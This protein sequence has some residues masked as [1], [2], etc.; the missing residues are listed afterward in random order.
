[1]RPPYFFTT[2]HNWRLWCVSSASAAKKYTCIILCSVCFVQTTGWVVW[3]ASSFYKYLQFRT[4]TSPS[5]HG[6]FCARAKVNVEKGKQIIGLGGRDGWSELISREMSS[7]C[8]KIAL[9]VAQLAVSPFWYEALTNTLTTTHMWRKDATHAKRSQE[10]RK[11]HV[12]CMHVLKAFNL[13]LII[14]I[15]HYSAALFYLINI[16]TPFKRCSYT[17]QGNIKQDSSSSRATVNIPHL[18]RKNIYIY[19]AQDPRLY[20]QTADWHSL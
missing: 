13:W 4:G 10:C 20:W 18:T 2:S 12:Q 17:T 5:L 6:A 11:T 19:L 14:S 3:M 9:S 7:C 15:N 1:M 16:W 8:F